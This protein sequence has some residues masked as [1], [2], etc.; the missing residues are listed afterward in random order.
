VFLLAAFSVLLLGESAYFGCLCVAGALRVGAEHAL[1]RNDHQTS[2]RLYQRALSWGGDPEVLETDVIELLLFGLDESE[3]GIKVDVALPPREAAKLAR[4]LIA[5]R[6]GQAPYRAYYWSLASDIY[7]HEGSQRRRDVPLDLA[8]LS[9]DPLQNLLPEQRLSLAA[10]HTAARLEPNNYLYHD[11]LVETYL[12]LGSP[13]RAVEPC[14][15]ALAAYPDFDGHSYLRRSDLPPALLEAAVRG[16]EAALADTSTPGAAEILVGAGQLLAWH[17]RTERAVAYFDRIIAIAP[18]HSEARMERGI[19]RYSLKQFREALEDFEWTARLLPERPEPHYWAGL[20][21]VAM[22]DP[23]GAIVHFRTARE[24]GSGDLKIFRALGETLEAQGQ[25]EEAQRQ[26]VAGANL[27]PGDP[28]A[29]LLLLS[30]HLRHRDFR[31]A[32]EA[33]TRIMTLNAAGVVLPEQCS[34]LGEGVR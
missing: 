25:V 33:C 13:E 17:G 32:S 27:H 29:W 7:G 24:T 12:E 5:R 21:R 22:G 20:T 11:L 31:A 9:E 28:N 2:W 3:V 1:Y 8:T 4:D 16:L 15:R 30:F 34:G 23:E 26:F 14:R 19:A 6:L 18:D 10:K